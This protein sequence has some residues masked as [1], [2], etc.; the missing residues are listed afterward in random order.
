MNSKGFDLNS[1]RN[2]VVFLTFFLWTFIFLSPGSA[3]AEDYVGSE[4]CQV[5]H[6]EKYSDWKVSGH[7]YKLMKSEE[8]RNRPIPLPGGFSWDDISYVIGGYKWKS[9]YM[10]D[11]GFIITTTFDRVGNPVSGRN[12]YN[13]LTGQWSDYHPDEVKP[14]N[15]GACHTTG[16]V[17]DEDAETDNDLSDNQ[18]GLPGIY[19]TFE[20]GGIH[21]EACH[22]PGDEMS[23]DTSADFCGTCHIRGDADTI[24]A[25][26]GFIR[27]HEQFNEFLA[28]PHSVLECVTC[29]DP[30]KRAEFSI[31]NECEDCHDNI[32]ESF[33]KDPMAG[34]GVE[35]EDCHM[36]FASKSAQA[37]G[38]YEGDIKT[39]LFY[40]NTDPNA[41]MFTEDGGF[42]ALD[43]N[44]KGAVTLDFACKRC[45]QNTDMNELARF[46]KNFHTRKLTDVG[47]NPGLT[48]TWWNSERAGEGFQV[49]FGYAGDELS[50]FATFYTYDSTG[51][52]V[53]LTA[54]PSA[55]GLPANGT[56]ANIDVF[57][58]DG[59]KWGDDFETADVNLT[60]WG[61]GSFLFITCA[62][63]KVT[64]KPSDDMKE[65]GFRN[66]SYDLTR[67]LLESGIQ[68]PTF[69]GNPQ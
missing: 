26:G 40:I 50:L 3:F 20:F 68:C 47:L 61:T 69:R 1:N 58:T 39:H 52:Q 32:A 16:W 25:S 49:E 34:Q 22:G 14:Y 27:H 46:A 65:Q 18:D 44:G 6:E 57:I 42:V 17:A 5:C 19:G 66:L 29:H 62:R 12:Q 35:C 24:P 41:N 2:L 13:A 60:Q 51:K 43:A 10:D 56:T 37:L 8:A 59:A 54:Q 9:R 7:P 55:P 30:H 15:C 33:A 38:D 45:H 21:C 36:P 28:G 11:D 31:V 53:W 23:V 48:G 63:G 64:L 67:D 4:A